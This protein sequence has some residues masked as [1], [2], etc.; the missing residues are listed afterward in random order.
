MVCWGFEMSLEVL[1]DDDSS[2]SSSS[3]SSSASSPSTSS[4]TAAQTVVDQPCSSRPR[5]TRKRRFVGAALSRINFGNSS[6]SLTASQ[7]E[8]GSSNSLNSVG[9]SSSSSG[10]EDESTIDESNDKRIRLSSSSSVGSQES[11]GRATSVSPSP[12]TVCYDIADLECSQGSQ[13]SNP[14]PKDS[15]IGDGEYELIGDGKE[16][17][18]V[19]LP[20]KTI[21]NCRV[22]NDEEYKAFM[23][24]AE[25][26]EMAEQKL[27]A[28]EAAELRRILLPKETRIISGR[29][30]HY[31]I[32]PNHDGNLQTYFTMHK[33]EQKLSELQSRAIFAQMVRMVQNCHQ[34]GVYFRDFMLKKI[35]FTDKDSL[36]I[37]FMFSIHDL[38]VLP[39]LARDEVHLRKGCCPAYTAPEMLPAP[40][41]KHHTYRAGPANVWSLGVL[42]YTLVTGRA[43]FIM[44]RCPRDLFRLIKQSKVTFQP[45]D[46]VSWS[47]KLL[48]YSLLRAQPSERPKPEEIAASEWV[49]KTSESSAVNFGLQL[50]L[51]AFETP[52]AAPVG[53]L[54]RRPANER[55]AAYRSGGE[56]RTQVHSL[57]KR[58]ADQMLLRAVPEQVVPD[59]SGD[60][61]PD[62]MGLSV[63]A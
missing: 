31:V 50:R 2:S 29:H 17:Q 36:N 43:P 56:Y 27:H 9:L 58:H 33:E 35:V 22:L 47:C 55:D 62:S 30:L 38:Q 54:L 6:S 42:L 49:R 15:L 63:V 18:A 40:N 25:R 37:R 11:N 28:E 41:S 10:S 23:V 20:T 8:T 52:I 44:A 34:I 59:F 53:H 48:L 21:H 39:D 45:K 57:L 12:E 1:V 61:M 13:R 60:S 46:R 16:C 4:S 19:H 32:S 24:I 3:S 5:Q 26:L 14:F 51:S 7:N